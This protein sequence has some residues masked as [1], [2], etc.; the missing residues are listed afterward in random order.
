MPGTVGFIRDERE[1][2]L[3]F[4]S[5][6]RDALRYTAYGLT[7]EQ[8]SAAPSASALSVAGI[9]KHV[10]HTER[11]WMRVLLGQEEDER[12]YHGEFHLLPGEGLDDALKLL[13]TVAAETEEI[14]AGLDLDHRFKLPP[15]PWFPE[16]TELSARW[17]LFHLIEEV[18]RHA[19]HADIVRESVDGRTFYALMAEAEGWG[20]GLWSQS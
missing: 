15:A 4:L 19:G 10:A 12:D 7:D 11:G 17:V 16:D 3:A 13:D 18:A 1:G 9:I 6:Q 5:Q 20:D 14:I 8:A 2:L